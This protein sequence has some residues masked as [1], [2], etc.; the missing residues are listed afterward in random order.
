MTCRA[1]TGW[2]RVALAGALLAACGGGPPAVPAP[3]PE[4]GQVGS[5]A[6]E[7]GFSFEPQVPGILRELKVPVVAINADYRPTDVAS[8][9]SDGVQVT[10]MRGVGHFLMLEDPARFNELLRAAL[11]KIP[12]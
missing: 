11:A 4:T 8:L 10:I 12:R 5:G 3:R 1:R 7:S 9:A 2:W 6:I